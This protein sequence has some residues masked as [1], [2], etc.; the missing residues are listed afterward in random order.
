[1]REGASRGDGWGGGTVWEGERVEDG[2]AHVGDGDLREDGAV[3]KFHQRVDCALRVDGDADLFG[4]EREEAASLNDLKALVHHGGGVDGDALTHD[5][6]GVLEGLLGGD[7]G[8]VGEGGVAEGAAGGG[9]PD[10]LDLGGFAAAHGLMDGVV[11][12]VDGEDLC[13]VLA[14]GGHDEV[15]GGDEA[16]FI[17]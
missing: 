10:L 4:R 13:V 6:G 7:V 17:G 3:Y 5:P 1:M 12:G 8:E 14:G 11:L 15:A 9:E 16:L 2:Q